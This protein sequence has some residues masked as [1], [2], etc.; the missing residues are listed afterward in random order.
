MYLTFDTETTGFKTNRLVQIAWLMV[1][2]D[3]T[4]VNKESLIVKPDGFEIPYEATKIHG[5]STTRAIR[6]GVPLISVL[7]MFEKQI[8]LCKYLIGHNI[9]FDVRVFEQEMARK[10]IKTELKTKKHI[11][12]MEKSKKYLNLKTKKNVLKKPKLTELHYRLFKKGFEN[13]HDAMGDTI[14]TAKC[15]FELLDRKVITL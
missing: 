5:I 7:E 6:E 9:S 10:G 8:Q 13:A 14:A 2:S 11:C 1:D 15:F 4:V 3:F 12:T